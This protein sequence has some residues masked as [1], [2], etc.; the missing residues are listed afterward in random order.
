MN[1]FPGLLVILC[2]I[3]TLFAGCT[4]PGNSAPHSPENKAPPAVE[5]TDRTADCAG[6]TLAVYGHLKSNTGNNTSVDL[7]AK[8]YD[9][10]GMILGEAR[11]TMDLDGNGT[12]DFMIW[13]PEGCPSFRAGDYSVSTEHIR[14]LM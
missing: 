8:A 9:E 3:T 6:D 10:R 4:S 11:K 2:V 12:I 14:F 7:V 13:I 5:I 1:R